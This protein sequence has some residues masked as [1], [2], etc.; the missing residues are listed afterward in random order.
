MRDNEVLPDTWDLRIVGDGPEREAIE[1]L[2]ASA[3]PQATSRIHLLGNKTGEDLQREVGN[4]R[5]T[6]LSSEW[7]ENMPYSGLESLAAQTPIIGARIGGIPE[8]VEEGRTGFTFE[9]GNAAD[10]R[11]V[12]MKAVDVRQGE[13]Q[14][15]QHAC[16]EYVRQRCLQMDY[17]KQLDT[18]YAGLIKDGE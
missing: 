14:H 6:V 2:I 15:M 10:L 4:A 17:V 11:D 13:Y 16:L 18:Q 12:L 7:R 1:Q 5:F 9:S 3:G 8:L